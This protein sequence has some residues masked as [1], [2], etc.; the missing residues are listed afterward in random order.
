[1]CVEKKSLLNVNY[2]L[3]YFVWGYNLL[4]CFD[5]FVNFIKKIR[6]GCTVYVWKGWMEVFRYLDFNLE[7]MFYLFSNLFFYFS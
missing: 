4:Y 7:V 3:L 5:V 6:S 1:M 2:L